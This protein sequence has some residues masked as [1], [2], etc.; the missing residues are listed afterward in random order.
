MTLQPPGRTALTWYWKKVCVNVYSALSGSL[1]RGGE[2]SP[3]I[4]E[5]TLQ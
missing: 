3:N 2:L 5:R 4:E 1:K